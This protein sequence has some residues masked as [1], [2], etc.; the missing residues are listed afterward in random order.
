L[1]RD[2]IWLTAL[3]TIAFAMLVALGFWQL[4]RLAWKQG[5]IERIET[6]VESEPIS[7]SKAIAQWKRSGD[8]D[9]LRVRLDGTFDHDKERHY[10]TI[11]DGKAGWRVITPLVTT[12]KQV[13]MADRGFVLNEL[14]DAKSRAAGQIAGLASVVGLARKGATQDPFAPD[15]S[16][17]KNSWFWRDLEGMARSVLSPQEQKWLVPFFVELEAGPVPGGWPKGG[18]TRLEL[19]NSHLQYALTWFGLAGGLLV[20]VAIYVI[21]R[22]RQRS[23]S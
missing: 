13:V 2:L 4:Q 11:V 12:G 6:R 15:N 3:A 9:Y 8:V 14:K 20:V 10:Y 7:L 23:I 5:L 21:G 18:V 16:P 17:E 1:K 22:L 19:P